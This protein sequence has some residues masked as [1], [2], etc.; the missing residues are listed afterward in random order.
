MRSSMLRTILLATTALLSAPALAAPCA[1]FGDV[2]DTSA[3]C[4]SV[5]WLKN[6]AV[7]QGCTSATLFCPSDAVSRL[8]MAAFMKRL[9]AALTP[10]SLQVE[11]STGALDLD[12]N[13]VVC[14]TADFAAEEFERIAYADLR[15]G[16]TAT[17]SVGLA[18]D[19]VMSLD[20]GATWSALNLNANR[21]FVAGNQWGTLT[22]LGFATLAAEQT[23]RWGVRVSRGGLAGGVD[24]S[25]GRCQ[26]RVRIH[27]DTN[28][29][30]LVSAGAS[31]AI[32]LPASANLAGTVSDDGLPNPPAAVSLAWSKASGPGTVTFG[33]AAALTTTATFSD[34]GT[35][36]LRLTANDGAL[37]GVAE[38]TITV[39]AQSL[40]PN[41]ASVAPP[42]DPTV[43]T[44]VFS[45][46]AF[47]YSGANPIQ[48]GVGPGTIQVQR[49]AVLRGKVLDRNGAALS[50]VKL[51]IV[52][53]P[54]F[55]S[56]LS[57][58][59]GVFDLAVNGGGQL[60]VNYQKAGVLPVQRQVNVPWQNYVTVPDVVMISLDVQVTTVNL[61]AAT[62]QVARGSAT[63]DADGTRRATLMVPQGTTAS[64]VLPNGTTQP[65]AT[66]NVRATEYT[67]GTNGLRAMP[68]PLPPNSGYTY[69][70]ELSA[71]E[72]MAAGA[73]SVVFS[74]PIASYTEN[75][76]AFPV[77][78]AV[79]AGYY[80]R[81]KAVWVPS[82]NGRVIKITAIN[83]G[84]ATVD[85]VGT[86][87]LPP[88][89]LSNAE[90]QQLASLYAVGQEL[91]RVP[92]TH[93]TPWDYNWP[94]GPPADAISPSETSVAGNDQVDD[95]TCSAGSVIECENQTLGE[96]VAL[97]GT[98]YT[99][100]YRSN[101]A[102]G[103]V[104]GRSLRIL[105]IGATVPASL[106]RIELDVQVAGRSFPQTFL[107]SPNLQALFTWDGVDAYGRVLQ[108]SQR[109]IVKIGYVYQAVYQTPATFA[110]SFSGFG[111]VTLGGSRPRS[112]ITISQTFETSIGS[113][114][115]R[116]VGLGG[117][118]LSS[119]HAYD[120]TAQVLHLGDG[121]RRSATQLGNVITTIAGTNVQG[122]QG[123][124]VPANQAPINFPRG[125]AVGAD[126][127]VFV[128][129]DHRIRRVGPDGIIT[130]VA[131]N[132]NSGF[133]G[134]GGPATLAEL[135]SPDGI[136]VG[137]DGSFY[138]SQ[139]SHHRIRR[140][141]PN[142]IV[143]TVAGTGAL[144]FSGD[145]GPATAA[146]FLDPRGVAVG[147]D[148]SL[149]IADRL[150]SRVRRVGLDGIITTVAGN[151]SQANGGNNV[152]AISVG[153]FEPVALAV[154][155]DGSLYIADS[156]GARVHRVGT[157]GIIRHFAGI[158]F[159][160]VGSSCP[161]AGD[162]GPA[163]AA[164][165]HGPRGL[166]VGADG[167][168]FI[169]QSGFG[170]SIR[171]VGPDGIITTFAGNN[172][173]GP[174][175][176]D[177]G[178]ATRSNV[179]VP[180]GLAI[181]P[182]GALYI[183]QNS[184]ANN[185]VRRVGPAL[186]GLGSA[187]VAVASQDGSRLYVFDP[188][189][190]HLR[191]LDALTNAAL[192]EFS[193]ASGRLA[194]VTQKT[195]G[196]DNVTTV[197]RNAAG[198]PTAIVAPFG[199]QTALTVDGNGFLASITNPASEQV[200]LAS[201]AGGLLTSFTNP[202]G[203]TSTYLYDG[204]GRL[205][206]NNDAAAG[207]QTLARNS[208]PA[209][210]SVARATALAR[211]TT[212]QIDNLPGSIR[213]RTTTAPDGTILLNEEDFDAG[214]RKLTAPD[215]TIANLERGGDPRFGMQAPTAKAFSIAL[216]AGPTLTASSTQTAVLS[217]P[218]DILS[219]TSLT[220]TSTVDGR[221]TT[222]T[223]TAAT[224]T[225]VVTAPS[226]RTAAL[227]TDTLGRLMQLDAGGLAPAT[228]TYDA[229]GRIAT[230]TRGSGAGA[231][232]YALA[233]NP[234]G[235]I[236]SISDPIGRSVQ[237]AYDGAGRV[238]SKTF[239][240]TR[241]VTFAYDASGN[242][243]GL[244][245][246]GRPTHTFAYSDRDE[247]VLAT[248][249]AVPGTGASSFS[250]NLDR[251]SVT[252]S[253]PDNRTVT[254][255]Y[256]AFGRTTSR[257]FATSGVTTGT[258]TLSY[259][260]SGRVA[261]AT[262]ASGVTTSYAYTGPL[263]ASESWSGAT[264]GNVAFG[265]DTSFR[266][267]SQSV[268]GANPVAFGYDSDSLLTSAGALAIT[269]D[270]QHGLATG[271]TLGAVGTT[272]GYNVFGE[273]TSYA[274]S[275]NATSLYNVTFVRDALGRVTQKSETLAGVTD[276]YAYTYD[277]VGQITQ[278]TKNGA[279]VESYGY[280]TNGNRISATVAG[281][282][283][284][285]AYDAQDRL[286][287]YGPTSFVY[288][289]AGELSSRTTGGQTTAYQ[290][291]ALGNL[292]GATLPGGT[293]ITYI[294]DARSRRVGKRVNGTAVQGLLYG[295]RQRPLAELDAAGALVSRFVY[296][297]KL[298]PAYMIK[299]GVAHRIVADHL[300]SVRLVVD[301][302]TGAIAQRIDYDTFGNV[303]A[304]TNPGFQPFGFAGGI[305][306]PATRL[307]RFGARDLDSSVGRWTAKDPVG[308]AG[309]DANLYRYVRNSPVNLV[310]H[311]GR[312]GNPFD[313]FLDDPTDEDISLQEASQK[314][315]AFDRKFTGVIDP[316][317][318]AEE[319][320]K[321]VAKLLRKL[322]DLAVGVSKRVGPIKLACFA[323]A[324]STLAA[325][326][327][328]NN[329][330]VVEQAAEN[331]LPVEAKTIRETLQ[332]AALSFQETIAAQFEG[333]FPRR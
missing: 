179:D 102:P 248:P 122:F 239:P 12:V 326:A 169:S 103:W 80:D 322:D 255:G 1:G 232:T 69:A 279:A 286:T 42:V 39:S 149:Y 249:P 71:D 305:Y 41:P 143:T 17:A 132:N 92:V 313:D 284:I 191:T 161:P 66:L 121:S 257:V 135:E 168:V 50:G 187:E 36:V 89:V 184:G 325:D 226:G 300:G 31:Q 295:D 195:G 224:R 302:S 223:Y 113:L 321:R 175:I 30:P 188:N 63:S 216:P 116:A 95:P 16:A 2:E 118:S 162:G 146:S 266:L 43:A 246:P 4:G 141:A 18:A 110:A 301:A 117:W 171:R 319:E 152:P 256:D 250:Y 221:T 57:R 134:E 314:N 94:F 275:A 76:L 333:L 131:G 45:G 199:Q 329:Q 235:F 218:A 58:S 241:I 107:A 265:F 274:A 60:T 303:L 253:R 180:H 6:R 328:A 227:S 182:D 53:H 27:G 97:V 213:N 86:G 292:V 308:F 237:F 35:Y 263:L 105:L 93:F 123:D 23:A 96:T 5:T 14:Q 9:G 231:R 156:G 289:A 251:Q 236:A 238:I 115:G 183:A 160:S 307:V 125:V 129:L 88:L 317:K 139:P 55:G 61:N 197:Q 15:F 28:A 82:E 190:L 153:L 287:S 269:R 315:T 98:P 114:D 133:G 277:T 101:R 127:S 158:C 331:A 214:T 108:G 194:S 65:I 13:P 159:Q 189:G 32:T 49:A 181:G 254:S 33:T 178:P 172:T 51:T 306:D 138:F 203:K 200:Q 3:F 294:V 264:V 209:G 62:M 261:S 144:G 104:A 320:D 215:G 24:L 48:T 90:V 119:H 276:T 120:F 293:A 202:R 174:I 136:A 280:D 296:A 87:S 29:P 282:S 206:R 298:A 205:T 77:G 258:D 166:A 170:L 244:T 272:T 147:P 186:S 106:A 7:T 312:T 281:I 222:A 26:L 288:T 20:A 11:A 242:L 47:L 243:A 304:D 230:V 268:N 109:A 154:G 68:A 177:G 271:S 54:Q 196:T 207:F 311:R 212:Y 217:D 163:T 310:D 59:D 22:D 21:G 137:P 285:G 193:Y 72:A 318:F 330:S 167:S 37:S 140:V 210:H 56:T 278:V 10:V 260:G 67:V 78:G 270:P 262:A 259:D 73:T 155:P 233:Y 75:F 267:A 273:M 52:G 64:L 148:G 124:G 299:G 38:V 8:Q 225:E 130:T 219:M 185:R 112:E 176:G 91:W 229:R 128:T 201:T 240:D 173:F 34:P 316:K 150:N 19:L 164:T 157:D 83:A 252:T 309:R 234:A 44:S 332:G 208:L 142:G 151:G 245:P 100:N 327:K 40:P 74:Q 79:P 192:V 126:G 85:S 99:L 25:A 111:G 211:T 81:V 247:L 228:L 145:G 46:S 198:N 220:S 297:G 283:A 70:V 165:I 324:L 84:V 323:F 204:D 290:Y 291:D